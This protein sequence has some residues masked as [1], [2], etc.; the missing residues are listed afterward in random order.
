MSGDRAVVVIQLLL[1][2]HGK[3]G[4]NDG[5]DVR[6]QALRLTAEGDGVTQPVPA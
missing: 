4:G 2:G 3:A 6:A 5:Q 1:G